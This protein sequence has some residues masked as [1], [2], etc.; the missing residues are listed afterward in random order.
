MKVE[1]IRHPREEDWMLAKIAALETV[2]LKAVNPPSFEWKRDLLNSMHSPLRVLPFY[3]RITDVP[4]WVSVHLVRHVHATPFVE[5]Q[6]NDRQNNYDRR[7]APQDAPVNMGWY[8][9]AEELINI[10][11]K[12]LCRL[13]S[14]ETR[15]VV[16][17]ICR[18]V[19]E[20]MPEF[21]SVLVPNCYYRGGR[22]TEFKCCGFNKNYPNYSLFKEG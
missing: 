14:K 21:E 10:S 7:K 5:S 16:E 22:C 8:M 3:F 19:I 20:I 11:H 13:A 2:S 18:Q 9:T 4:S 17:E 6:R 12:R 15:E 1:I